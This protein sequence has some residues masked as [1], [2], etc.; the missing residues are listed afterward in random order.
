MKSK[1][2]ALWSVTEPQLRPLPSWPRKGP[3]LSGTLSSK[4]ASLS[5]H[6]EYRVRASWVLCLSLLMGAGP[7][8]SSH[9]PEVP[10]K[11]ILAPVGEKVGLVCLDDDYIEEL[12]PIRTYH[13]PHAFVPV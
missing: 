11:L 13:V 2:P 12:S 10:A 4:G 8:T 9:N 1:E 5:K 7:V 3:H 6:R